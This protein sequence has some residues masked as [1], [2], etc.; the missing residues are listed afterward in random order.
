MNFHFYLVTIT[1]MFFIYYL[2]DEFDDND[3][4]KK[5]NKT[6]LL[7]NIKHDYLKID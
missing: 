6:D 5:P 2:S 3:V 4:I 1:T 7:K